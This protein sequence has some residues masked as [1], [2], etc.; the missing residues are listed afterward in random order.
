MNRHSPTVAQARKDRRLSPD[1]RRQA[2]VS[3][4]KDLFLTKGY[5]ATPLEEVVAISG[6]SLTTLYQLFGNKQGLWEAIVAEVCDQI[7]APLQ[8]AMT[9]GE[10]TLGEPRAA[11]K[12]F[13]MRLDA[14][15]RSGES[16]GVLRLILAEGGK[17]PE[18]TRT[19]FAA[20]PDAAHAIVGDYLKAQ[21][22]AGRLAISD[23]AL[24][25]QQFIALVC[26][27]TMLRQACGVLE[28]VAPED[29]E[30]RLDAAV[31]MFLK[32]YAPPG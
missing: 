28:D 2:F 23:T 31:N 24:A 14:L 5:A 8:E 30:R 18:L 4:A 10:P 11:L 25:T 21:V 9:L 27:D 15:E 3:A 26:G 6:G 16:A 7:T 12:N 22:A 19:L 13:A 17:C 29:A 32:V 20:G 1:A